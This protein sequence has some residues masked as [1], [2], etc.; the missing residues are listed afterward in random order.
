MLRVLVDPSTFLRQLILCHTVS[1][2]LQRHNLRRLLSPRFR[3]PLNQ[4]VPQLALLRCQAC[5]ILQLTL[6][7]YIPCP[8]RESF[9]HDD[10]RIVSVELRLKDNGSMHQLSSGLWKDGV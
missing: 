7:G 9:S 6:S 10:L 1:H 8:L 3:T 5:I 2:S 4:I